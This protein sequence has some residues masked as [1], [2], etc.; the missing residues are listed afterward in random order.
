MKI[1][2][3]NYAGSAG[4]STLTKH[5]LVPQL[6]ARRIDIE[7]VNTGDGKPDVKIAA[8]KFS[9]LAGEMEMADEGINFII[10]VG[11]SNAD[12]MLAN[13]ALL[14]DTRDSID[15]WI[16]PVGPNEKSRLDSI[17]TFKRLRNIAIPANKIVLILNQIV[18]VDDVEDVYQSIFL[19]RKLGAH[20]S[21][22]CVLEAAVFE[23][24]KSSDDNVFDLAVSQLDLKALK[25][26]AQE[27]PNF[28]QSQI[29]EELTQLGKLHVIYQESRSAAR[30]LRAVFNATPLSVNYIEVE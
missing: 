14:E 6:N 1:V 15:Y 25:K 24:L 16:I 3:I 19:L 10:D 2:V 8:K 5:L 30:N 11:T 21:T 27:N 29:K 17:K 13:F 7:T 12:A 9:V 28:N 26:A 22:Q 18:E 20:V 4:K 23:K